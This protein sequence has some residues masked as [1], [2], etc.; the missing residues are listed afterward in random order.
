VTHDSLPDVT[1]R[2]HPNTLKFPGR[3]ISYLSDNVKFDPVDEGFV[4][5][6]A[7]VSGALSKRLE[8]RFASPSNICLGDGR[9]GDQFHR[10]NL[11]LTIANSVTTT[12]FDFWTLPEPERHGYVAGQH[13]G[14]KFPTEF[15]ERNLCQFAT[16]SNPVAGSWAKR[17]CAGCGHLDVLQVRRNTGKRDTSKSVPALIVDDE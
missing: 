6:R 4:V 14:S 3:G 9:E 5:N 15:H 13:V 11:N 12:R 1:F 17:R 8:I 10:V 16:D 7:C 2:R